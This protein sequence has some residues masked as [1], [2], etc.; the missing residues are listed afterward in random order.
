MAQK[1]AFKQ[2]YVSAEEYIRYIHVHGLQNN[3]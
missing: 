3:P 1:R 2:F